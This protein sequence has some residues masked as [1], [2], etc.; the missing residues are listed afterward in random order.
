MNHS[1]SN[2]EVYFMTE[3][4]YK[5]IIKR[6]IESYR[7]E[8][9]LTRRAMQKVDGILKSFDKFLIDKNIDTIEINNETFEEWVNSFK[10]TCSE[11]TI[12]IKRAQIVSL[13]QYMSSVGVKC[14]VPRNTKFK[15]SSYVP[16]I[17]TEDEMIKIFSIADEWRDKS[18]KPESALMA[19][20]LL[21]RLL[22]STGMRVSEAINILNK[23][24]DFDQRTIRITKT[25]NGCERISP[26]NDTLLTC[27]L[28]YK[29]FRDELP[30]L[31]I[32]D[33]ES[34]FLVNH[35]GFALNKETIL[36]RFHQITKKAGI[37]GNNTKNGTRIH[38]LRHTACIHV[39]MKLVRE[40]YDLYNC[41][42]AISAYMGHLSIFST[43][44]YLRFTR[45]MFPELLKMTKTVSTPINDLLDNA[46]NFTEDE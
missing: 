1:I 20:P 19:M 33:K 28:Q 8:C 14:D 7:K 26:I 3:Y 42:P 34:H 45:N 17:F 40:G 43:E 22:Y 37:I 25:K 16:Y 6:Y 13:L 27:M 12:Y 30:E 36:F 38:D 24:I 44:K 35:H 41:L 21:L 18:L 2:V 32:K 39:M 4:I 15:P 10:A 9:M 29:K 31:H 5:S 46:F 11:S 23:D